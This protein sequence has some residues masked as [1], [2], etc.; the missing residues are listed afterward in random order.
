MN[1][2]ITFT[3]LLQ[4]S[5]IKQRM[6]PGQLYLKDKTSTILVS[7]VSSVFVASLSLITFAHAGMIPLYSSRLCQAE[8]SRRHSNHASQ[9]TIR[10]PC[11]LFTL[12]G[13]VDFAVSAIR[14]LEFVIRAEET[15]RLS[16]GNVLITRT[17]RK[18]VPGSLEIRFPAASGIRNFSYKSTFCHLHF[19][20]FLFILFLFIRHFSRYFCLFPFL[21]CKTSNFINFEGFLWMGKIS[22]E[23]Q[24]SLKYLE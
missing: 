2:R 16:D 4:F 13:A 20:L 1:F 24:I 9:S 12:L 22:R 14:R 3:R 17:R 23:K 15:R 19:D 7:R 10:G 18:M 5:T 21:I 11:V 6:L 8:L